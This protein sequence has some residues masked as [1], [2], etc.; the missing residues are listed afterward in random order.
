MNQLTARDRLFVALD[1]ATVDKARALMSTLGDNITCYKVGLELLCSGGIAFASELRGAG[2]TVFL[3]LKLLD[4]P[5]T[6]EKAVANIA[7]L[8]IDFL[9]VHGVDAKTMNA[10]VRGRGSSHL[11]LLAVTV[12]TSLDEADLEQQGIRDTRLADLVVHRANLAKAA[13]L[14]GCIASG[15]EAATVRAAIGAGFL[16]VTPGIRSG[17]A[18]VLE[19]SDDQARVTTPASAIRAGATHLVVGRPISDAADPR[20][21][22][23]QIVTEIARATQ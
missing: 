11:K 19:P 20:A 16:V 14:D 15:R 8:G 7:R 4:I 18:A 23:E 1:F 13:G 3:D 9:T 17:G 10:A 12:L 5:N 21:A 2:K 22:A 6:V